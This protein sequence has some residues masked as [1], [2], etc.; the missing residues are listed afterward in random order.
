MRIPNVILSESFI[1]KAKQAF[2]GQKTPLQTFA[3]EEIFFSGIDKKVLNQSDQIK[4]S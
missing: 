2:T 1:T 3:D 4:K